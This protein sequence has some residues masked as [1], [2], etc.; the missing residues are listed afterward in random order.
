MTENHIKQIIVI[1]FYRSGTS[2]LGGILHYLGVSMGNSENTSDEWNKKG[3]FE[4]A[5][6]SRL[7]NKMTWNIE[8][9]PQINYLTN[10]KS[11]WKKLKNIDEYKKIIKQYIECK[12]KVKK[13]WGIKDPR[14]PP[15]YELYFPFLKNL[16]I[17]VI[18]RNKESVVRSLQKK[19]HNE[20]KLIEDAFDSY[21]E[22]Y[23][24]I[25]QKYNCLSLKY[26]NI[27]DYPEREVSKI[28]RF[29]D[30]PINREAI[31]FIDIS[32]RHN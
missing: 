22:I 2:M 20:R 15:F 8:A 25:E 10:R 3:Y 28:S 16:Y 21:E 9:E 30:I 12:N 27:T 6:I 13:I 29:I 32:L 4:D 26:E 17:I 11:G 14:L 23:K 19:S 7:N 24:E 31:E 5:F 1:G 18:R